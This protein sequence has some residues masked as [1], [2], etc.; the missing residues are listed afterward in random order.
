LQGVL[1]DLNDAVNGLGDTFSQD[2]KQALDDLPPSSP[3]D[4][5]TTPSSD[6]TPFELPPGPIDYTEDDLSNDVLGSTPDQPVQPDD[7]DKPDTSGSYPNPDGNDP[8]G[9]AGPLAYPTP[10]GPPGGPVGIVTGAM[11]GALSFRP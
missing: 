3:L 4:D 9:P 5:L 6:G 10:D 11:A 1:N 7:P 8:V 2:A